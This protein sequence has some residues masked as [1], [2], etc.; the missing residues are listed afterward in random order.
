MIIVRLYSVQC[1]LYACLSRLSRLL[2]P[3]PFGATNAHLASLRRWQ[4]GQCPMQHEHVV[5]CRINLITRRGKSLCQERLRPYSVACGFGSGN[6]I[7]T[8]DLQPRVELSIAQPC[9]GVYT[10]AVLRSL[11]RSSRVF[12]G[13]GLSS[14]RANCTT[15]LS[16]ML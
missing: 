1:R 4:Q 14:T 9:Q 11:S 8:C 7:C 15:A 5:L 16:K 12:T 6:R 3:R 13:Q 2:M 10:V